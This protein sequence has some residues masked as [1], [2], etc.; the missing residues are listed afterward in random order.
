M[1]ATWQKGEVISNMASKN[2]DKNVA[3]KMWTKNL[4]R[5]LHLDFLPW[6]FFVAAKRSEKYKQ[7]SSF[8]YDFTSINLSI[9]KINLVKIEQHKVFINTFQDNPSSF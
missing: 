3:L 6:Q 7:N 8:T 9:F 4:H 1:S 2:V 5:K